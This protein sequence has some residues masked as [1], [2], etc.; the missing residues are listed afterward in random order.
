MI[1]K[2]GYQLLALVVLLLWVVPAGA[3]TVEVMADG[4]SFVPADVTIAV[5]DSVHWTGIGGF[6][7]VAEVDD[8]ASETY[9]GG[10]RSGDVGDVTEFTHTFN[11]MGNFFY[12]CEPHAPAGMRGTVTVTEQTPTMTPLGVA[13]MAV[14]VISAGVVVAVKR[15]RRAAESGSN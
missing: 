11:T 3:D 5:G 9:N 15:L 10:F 2:S 13:V 12:I 14:L 6:H 1:R 8:A 4:L 7:N